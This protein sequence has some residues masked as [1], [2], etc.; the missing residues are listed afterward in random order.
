MF[1]MVHKH[2]RKEKQNEST[3][4]EYLNKMTRGKFPSQEMLFKIL[5]VSC[6]CISVFPKISYR[7]RKI[8]TFTSFVSRRK[9]KSK[10]LAMKLFRFLTK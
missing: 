9:P 3:R 5:F 2:S 10:G 8:E 1:S 6:Q 4:T 7:I